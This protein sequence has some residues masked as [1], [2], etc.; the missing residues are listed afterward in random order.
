MDD[1]NEDMSEE[2]DIKHK[3]EKDDEDIIDPSDEKKPEEK[4]KKENIITPFSSPI[5]SH[6]TPP[7]SF[8]YIDPIIKLF[9]KHDRSSSESDSS[10]SYEQPKKRKL[11]E[12]SEFQKS[13]IKSQKENFDKNYN[14]LKDDFRFLEEYETKI[15]KDTNLDIMFIMDLTGSMGIWLNEAKK[16]IKKIIEEIYDNNPGSKIRISF[17]GYRDFIDE[18]EERKYDNIE[19][20]ENLEEFNNFLSKLDCSGG[21]D[22]PEDVVGALQQG[23]NMKWESNAKYAVL[24]AD[25][26]CHGKNYHNITYDK[27]P[28]GDPS[29]VKLE[30]VMKQFYEKN[31][32]FY[33]IEINNNTRTMFNIMKN[34]YNDKEKFHVEKLG[35]SVDQFSFFVTFSASV[36]LGNEKYRKV[37]FSEILKNYR[38]ETINKI[39]EKYLK[40]N[41]NNNST[42]IDSAMTSQ[43]ISQIENLNLGGEDKKLFDFINR[44]S[45]LS[46]SGEN[47]SNNFNLNEKTKNDNNNNNNDYIKVDLNEENIK[48]ME[49]KIVNYNLHSLYYEKNSGRIND[50]VNPTFLE[51]NFKTKLQLSF[52]SFKK[53][54]DKKI[55]EFH[56]IDNILNKEKT[57]KIPFL[58]N[59]SEYNNPSE[60]IKKVAYEDLICEQMADYFNILINEKLPNLKQF[61][62]FQRHILYEIDLDNSTLLDDFFLNNKYIISE[63]ST[64]IQLNTSVPPTKRVL[65]N[66]SHFSYQ[67]SGGQLFVT[68]I[69]YDK[70][71]KKVT[72]YKIYNLKGEGYKKILE[73]FSNHICDNTCKILKLANPRKK[74]NPIN[75]NENF[76]MDRYTLD[77][78]LCECCSCPIQPK[79]ESEENKNCGFCTWKKA[80]SKINVVCSK[81]KFPFFYST[82]TH[83]CQFINYPD[84]CPKCIST[85]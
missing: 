23:L 75:V 83:N 21:G 34:M 80:Q 12:L 59:K 28:N 39:M 44:M 3:L 10:D 2:N 36:L 26:P 47:N 24:V 41:I 67:I 43:L 78:Y 84:K 32:T 42:N 15:F 38:D 76:F 4:I 60:Y 71:L 62:K 73:F 50:W 85:F 18:K 25:A 74:L 57:G 19:F 11:R 40:Q 65:Q 22:E 58:I 17:I 54:L 7:K 69:N 6:K 1:E 66:F 55:Y 45:D 5:I 63:D 31:I 27:F 49:S 37:K 77:I 14:I 53:N 13:Y 48:K 68:D 16:N 30:D 82:Y 20:T 35:N 52:S 9:S 8:S 46:L 79:E 29:G 81:C 64:S 56:F 70:E 51:K 61:I 72:E 33:C